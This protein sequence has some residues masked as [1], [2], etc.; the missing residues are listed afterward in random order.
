M[1]LLFKKDQ[2]DQDRLRGLI[3]SRMCF[4]V[5]EFGV[6]HSTLTIAQALKD[7]ERDWDF[8]SDPPDVKILQAHMFTLFSVDASMYWLN[9]VKRGLP[10]DLSDYVNFWNSRARVGRFNGQLCHYYDCLPDIVPD[11]IYLD[12]PD[13]KDVKG[14]VNGLSFKCYERTPMAADILLMESTLLPGCFILVDGRTNNARF[15]ERNLQRDWEV[16]W[17]RE[18]DYTTFILM[19]TRLGKHQVLGKDF[20]K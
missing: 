13:P 14:D 6:G 2:A 3:R 20:V 15:L 10:K 9:H 11:F 5:L 1:E 8:L 7:N 18:G 4:T 12:G 16:D 19:E 17:D